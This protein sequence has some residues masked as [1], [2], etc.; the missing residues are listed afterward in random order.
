MVHGN[1]L[2]NLL[3]IIWDDSKVVGEEFSWDDEY[4][5]KAERDEAYERW[6]KEPGL[7]N[8]DRD[9]QG[10]DEEV[11]RAF[12]SATILQQY[13]VGAHITKNE[14]EEKWLEEGKLDP[15][16]RLKDEQKEFR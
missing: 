5:T 7:Y 1:G 6:R 16:I 14:L 8:K 2:D 11:F 4:K 15:D 10:S 13:I 3:K 12:D 9:L